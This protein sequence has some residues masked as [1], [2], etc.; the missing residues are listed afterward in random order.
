[1]TREDAMEALRI[2]RELIDQ[3]DLRILALLNERAVIVEQIGHIK[4]SAAMQIYEPRREDQVFLNVTEHN[5][6]PL[7]ADAVKRVFE[8]VIDEMR[9]VQSDRMAADS[10]QT[11][12][13]SC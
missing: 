8:R 1:M 6:G 2:R 4:Q 3:V 9:K 12:N 11:G 5:R 10:K 7:T 13:E